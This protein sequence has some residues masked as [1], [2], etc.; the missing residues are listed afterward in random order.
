V[1]DK[2][3]KIKTIME[4]LQLTSFEACLGSIMP[5]APWGPQHNQQWQGLEYSQH[6]IQRELAYSS[7]SCLKALFTL[8][9]KE[10]YLY[11]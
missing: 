11:I 5:A 9:L 10:T 3:K 6:C 2:N 4:P 8:P 7:H 1:R